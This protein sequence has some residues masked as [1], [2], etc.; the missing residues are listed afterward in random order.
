[1]APKMCDQ[2][3]LSL[4][5]KTCC[6]EDGRQAP[7]L[8]DQKCGAEGGQTG[9]DPDN[10]TNGAEDGESAGAH[11]TPALTF[12]NITPMI[13]DQQAPTTAHCTPHHPTS[14]M[15]LPN[16]IENQGL[17]SPTPIPRP[18]HLNLQNAPQPSCP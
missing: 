11:A 5:D 8:D 7:T 6:A 3:G 2:Q 1:M 9:A 15:I 10:Q 14:P 16:P 17:M 4:D 12:R 18:T 13:E